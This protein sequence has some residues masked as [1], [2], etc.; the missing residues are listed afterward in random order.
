MFGMNIDLCWM[1]HT[2]AISTGRKILMDKFKGLYGGS[3]L[4]KSFGEDFL[5]LFMLL[6]P[7]VSLVSLLEI[8]EL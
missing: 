2:F 1:K 3:L 5:Q 6:D 4:I 7:L 8:M